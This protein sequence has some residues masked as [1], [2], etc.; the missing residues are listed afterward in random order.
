MTNFSAGTTEEDDGDSIEKLHIE[1]YGEVK[2]G[3]RGRGESKQ[4]DE[5]AILIVIESTEAA[6]GVE[7]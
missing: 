7:G 4:L 2:D 6:N 3:L 1:G 5:N